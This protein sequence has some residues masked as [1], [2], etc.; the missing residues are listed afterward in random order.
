L[1][2]CFSFFPFVHLVKTLS[3]DAPIERIIANGHLLFNLLGVAFFAWTIPLFE[4]VLNRLLPDRPLT[5][6]GLSGG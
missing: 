2:V 6:T 5:D 4:Q 3:A 1:W